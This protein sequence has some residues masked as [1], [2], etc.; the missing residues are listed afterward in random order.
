MTNK[1]PLL[2]SASWALITGASSG[3]GQEFST[4]LAKDGYSLVLV[5][6]DQEKLEFLAQNLQKTYSIQV[7]CFLIDLAKE[8]AIAE[9]EK[10]LKQNNITVSILINN[11]GLGQNEYFAEGD[12]KKTADMI[13]VN[14][15]TLTELTRLLL[16]D[17][18]KHNRGKILNVG[19]MA[20]FSP[21]PFMAVYFASKAYVFSFSRAIREELSNTNIKV[22]VFCPGPIQTPFWEKAGASRSRLMSGFLLPILTPEKAAKIAY[23]ALKKGKNVCVPGLLAKIIYALRGA[24]GTYIPLKIAGFL[25]RPK[26]HKGF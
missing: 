21:G 24:L 7:H 4:L 25:N 23:A 12:Q 26:S 11:A 19:S 6:R 10:K 5:A 2:K 8:D 15:K 13:A 22:T 9:I 16:P 17:M 1:E 3:L 14:I 18:I 20:A